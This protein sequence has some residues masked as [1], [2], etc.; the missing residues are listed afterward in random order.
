MVNPVNRTWRQ[1][2]DLV[3]A[4]SESL[5]LLHV[6]LMF[7]EEERAFQVLVLHLMSKH[8]EEGACPAYASVYSSRSNEWTTAPLPREDDDF[9]AD[10]LRREPSWKEH[11]YGIWPWV[12]DDDT[13]VS[14][15]V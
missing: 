5:G 15:R 1:L 4:D 2:P 13:V 8:E 14:G 10:A 6:C 11:I 9:L 3:D 12:G 7:E